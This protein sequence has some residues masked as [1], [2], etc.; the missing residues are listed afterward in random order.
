MIRIARLSR[1]GNSL[2]VT[3]HPALLRELQWRR[4]DAIAVGV[5]TGRLVCRKVQEAEL[6]P[7]PPPESSFAAGR[8]RRR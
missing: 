2:G 1:N 8:R 4:G 7:P 5:D 3:V 6:L